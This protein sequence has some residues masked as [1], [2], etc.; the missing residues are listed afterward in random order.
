MIALYLFLRQRGVRVQMWLDDELPGMYSF[1]PELDKIVR[2]PAS[3]T[4]G[5][6]I[7]VLDA[8]DGGV[9]STRVLH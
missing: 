1:L 2:P 5:E 7:I 6:L 9:G 3:C 8:G 4:Q